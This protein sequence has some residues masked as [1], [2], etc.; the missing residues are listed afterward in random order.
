MTDTG[1]HTGNKNSV[2]VSPV[3]RLR[4]WF[5]L[6]LLPALLMAPVSLGAQDEPLY[7]E[8][9]VYV[10]LPYIGVGE[11]DALIRDADV[12]LPVTG[13][14]DFLKIR[15]VPSDDLDLITGF[16]IN[17]EAVYT[18][19]RPGNR[20]IYG[21]RTWELSDG[22]L[23][24][25]ETNLYLKAPWY[26]RIFGLECRFSFRDLTV[27]IETKQ[28][29]PGIK[30]LKIEEMRANMTRLRG[31]VEVDTTIGRSYP[32]FRF[33]M[34]DW[35]VYATEQEG[36]NSQARLNLSL[37]SVI[38]GGEANVSLNYNTGDPFTEKQQYYLWRHVNNDRTLLRQVMAGK[39]TSYATASIYD[40]VVGIQLTNT[41]TTFRR[42]FGTYNL[43]DRTEPNWTV[44]LYVNN[45]LVDYVKADASGFFTFEVPL[46]YGTTMVKLKFY[47]PWGEERTREQS[48]SIP[49]NFIPHR[50]L[51]YT[52]SA[53]VVEDSL[54]SR[55][56]RASISYGATRF[57]TVGGGAEYLSSVATGPLMPFVNASVRLPGNVLVSGEYTY[58]VRAR[59]T[60]AYRLPSNIQ[61][62]L[63]YIRY[64]RDQEAISF[65]YLEERKA[66]LSLPIKIKKFSAYSRLS[67]NQ[68][69]LP[70]T[71]YSTA[72][73][74]IAG[75]L[76]GINTNLTT[77]G[78]FPG[79]GD[80]GLY[81]TLS[82]GIRLPAEILIMP[83]AQFSY[84]DNGFMTAKLGLEKRIFQKG[85]VNLSFEQN[86]SH[87]IS[88]GEIGIR[89]DFS[90]AQAG[91]SARQTNRE[92][93]LVQYA[94][95]SLINDR[96]TGWLKADNR[97]NVGRG[98]IS[99]VAFMDLN[100]NGRRDPGEPK[101]PGMNVR[102]NSGRLERSEKDTTI[103]ITGLEPYV[104]YFIEID[105]SSFE[106][107]SW[108][109]EKKSYAVVADPNMMKLIEIPVYVRGEATGTVMYEEN[110][111]ASGLGRVI[112][113]FYNSSGIV[114]GRAL[115]EE[116]GYFSWFGLAPGQY[117]IRIDTA[118]L[119]RLK[120][121]SEPEYLSFSVMTSM[122][123]DYID[124]LDFTLKRIA[125]VPD[126]IIADTAEV[127]ADTAVAAKPVSRV[128]STDTSY[129]VIHE[130]T[131]E[132]MTITEDYYAVQ[133]GAFRTKR[134]AEIMQK[135]VQAALDKNVELFEEDG[136]WKVRITG[137][138]DR[139]D[140]EKY[141]PII[142]DQG[143][144][145]IWVITNKAIRG[146][147]ITISKEDSLALVRERLAEAPA[148]A[149][150]PEQKPE[151][152]PVPVVIAG[153]TVQLGAFNS[154]E[155]TSA[156]TD[157]LLAAAEKLVTI[158]NEGG[159]FKI[160]ISGFAD[161][162]EVRDFIP[163]LRKYGFTDILVIHQDETE[164]V[165]VAPAVMPPAADEPQPVVPL[166]AEEPGVQ[167]QPEAVVPEKPA[168]EKEV[169]PP[170]PV[171][172]FILHAASYPKLSQA[173]RAKLKI[174]RKLK[175]PVEI[176]E[177]WDRYRVVVTGFFTREETYPYYPE[178]A[179][180]GFS[181]IFVY[182]KSLIDR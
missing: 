103:H 143:I 152:E 153:T 44:E 83:Q 96:P 32:G 45:V 38:A 17:P 126:S 172:R 150:E 75:S 102:S 166:P 133:F 107:I 50:E 104:K 92:T 5:L 66:S 165:P 177:E 111:V 170:P 167:E 62:D 61:I 60:L 162:S 168:V 7:D 116:D 58:G 163:L 89:Y 64:D 6:L 67:W 109:I 13:L 57:L 63:D 124:G 154:L 56:S 39:I 82:L 90:F 151:P 108:R 94:R 79:E 164:L 140:L 174:E 25:S 159:L 84:T 144:T 16:F 129:L 24:R 73:W 71:N 20:I 54:W 69:V 85:F 87:D 119:R 68:I 176:M 36:G 137:F 128:I 105:E 101:A 98:G 46:V 76:L 149:P 118:Q 117:N 156:M 81:S 155:E 123:G 131:R 18:I 47:G 171:P 93:T 125:A 12:Y 35:S 77:Y 178:L 80:P 138:E 141:I 72:E 42:S 114:T 41:P 130:V 120:M 78:I 1:T 86:F 134:Y 95:G 23:V 88:M 65:N 55:Y 74:M 142:H 112:V 49:Y 173:E 19:D 110:G 11:I 33:G 40:P 29:L 43:T 100:A 31:E 4:H 3:N 48:L 182:E 70:S 8:I 132:L 26:G 127:A 160:Q 30:E 37:G 106:N 121:I 180:M 53:G 15:N 14:F 113:N 27:S 158:R 175:L 51:E 135:K 59:G 145:E 10:R 169:V 146:E 21:G 147:W 52:V 97:T 2:P 181:D 9:S 122:E 22:D 179:G 139:E 161:T 136:F 115:T 28:E 148:P 91:A 34:A 157:R 99:V